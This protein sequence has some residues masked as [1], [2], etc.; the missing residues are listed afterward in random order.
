MRPEPMPSPELPPVLCSRD[1]RQCRYKCEK[2]T[3]LHGRPFCL[4]HQGV[5]LKPYS[6]FPEI[7]TKDTEVIA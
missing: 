5:P 3:L 1:G 4:A 6:M 2:F 7:Q